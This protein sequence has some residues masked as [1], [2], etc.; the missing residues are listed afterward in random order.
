MKKDDDDEIGIEVSFAARKASAMPMKTK[1]W[2]CTECGR[3]AADRKSLPKD[4]KA[5]RCKVRKA[6]CL[7]CNGQY[8]VAKIPGRKH[9]TN[10]IV[11]VTESDEFPLGEHECTKRIELKMPKELAEM[12][13]TMEDGAF[14]NSTEFKEWMT[15]QVEGIIAKKVN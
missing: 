10:T 11:K 2:V 1:M 13:K 12:A 15:S 14:F 8:M 6:I 4:C 7:L 5:V 3:H 9:T